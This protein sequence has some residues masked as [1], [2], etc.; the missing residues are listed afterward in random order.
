MKYILPTLALAATCY[1]ADDCAWHDYWDDKP[2]WNEKVLFLYKFNGHPH[3][4]IHDAYE[5]TAYIRDGVDP[6]PI[7]WIELPEGF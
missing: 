1:A 2:Q 3:G 4:S 5:F 6:E 7:Y